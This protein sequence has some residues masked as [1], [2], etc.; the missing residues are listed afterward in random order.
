MKTCVY[1]IYPFYVFV[2]A[3]AAVVNVP[4]LQNATSATISSTP[5]NTSTGAS[6]GIKS[7]GSSGDEINHSHRQEGIPNRILGEILSLDHRLKCFPKLLCTIYQDD[8]ITK[9]GALNATDLGLAYIQL[10]KAVYYTP[11]TTTE[12]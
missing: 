9:H 5:G 11:T 8:A 1:V 3:F 2:E 4:L 7:S 10:L 6:G 12:A